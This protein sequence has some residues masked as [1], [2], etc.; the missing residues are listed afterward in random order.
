MG[1]TNKI[2]FY[3]VNHPQLIQ[4]FGSITF[5][6]SHFILSLMNFILAVDIEVIFLLPIPYCATKQNKTKFQRTKLTNIIL[7]ILSK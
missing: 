6:Y 2:P 5:I 4:T 1:D 7:I 3:D